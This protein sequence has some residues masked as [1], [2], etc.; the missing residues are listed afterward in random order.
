MSF[1]LQCDHVIFDDRAQ[2]GKT[3]ATDL[4]VDQRIGHIKPDDSLKIQVVAEEFAI[5]WYVIEESTVC[6]SGHMYLAGGS[7][8]T[9]ETW[10][11]YIT[12]TEASKKALL[13]LDLQLE[14]T[15]KDVK[16][17]GLYAALAIFDGMPE[18]KK[19]HQHG[20]IGESMV[21]AIT[22]TNCKVKGVQPWKEK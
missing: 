17:L 22:V 16:M 1:R 20:F 21:G 2:I 3:K 8:E 13:E 10:E 15:G 7:I 6:L 5:F 18:V 9:S 19:I 12:I 14:E 11:D 4:F